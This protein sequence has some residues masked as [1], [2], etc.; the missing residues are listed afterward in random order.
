MRSFISVNSAYKAQ[1]LLSLF[2]E[3]KHFGINKHY[4]S[5]PETTFPNSTLF[6]LQLTK[7]PKVYDFLNDL[8]N[9][10]LMGI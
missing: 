6:S 3:A 10:I 9:L 4:F 5:L 7:L 1:K 2:T 8:H